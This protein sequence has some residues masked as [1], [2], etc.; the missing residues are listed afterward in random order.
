M[1][2]AEFFQRSGLAIFISH[3]E[4]FIQY[5]Q[6]TYKPQVLSHLVMYIEMKLRMS[7][8]T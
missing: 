3:V 2:P 1:I 7:A 6:P 5:N 8:L 4:W